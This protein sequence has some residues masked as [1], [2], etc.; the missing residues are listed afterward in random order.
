MNPSYGEFVEACNSVETLVVVRRNAMG[1]V[2]FTG[3]GQWGLHFPLIL[4]SQL[5]TDADKGNPTV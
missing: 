4:N 1:R 2:V 3:F 5:R